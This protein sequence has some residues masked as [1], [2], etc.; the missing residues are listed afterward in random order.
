MPGQAANC[1]F[2]AVFYFRNWSM[3]C[4]NFISLFFDVQDIGLSLRFFLRDDLYFCNM[5]IFSL[6]SSQVSFDSCLFSTFL[7][8]SFINWHYSSQDLGPV[9]HSVPNRFKTHS[10]NNLKLLSKCY[11]PLEWSREAFWLEKATF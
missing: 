5:K 11:L 8:F 7:I 6:I 2:C 1:T 10:E 9:D 4:F 3:P